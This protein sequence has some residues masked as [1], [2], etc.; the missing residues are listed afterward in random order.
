MRIVMQQ[1]QRQRQLDPLYTFCRTELNKL[2]HRDK[3]THKKTNIHGYHSFSHHSIALGRLLLFFS[4]SRSFAFFFVFLKA[5]PAVDSQ[6]Q[7]LSV[8]L[9]MMMM[10][11][12]MMDQEMNQNSN[13]VVVLLPD[14]RMSS[15]TMVVTIRS[16]NKML[17]S[18]ETIEVLHKQVY[19]ERIKI[20]VVV[21][22]QLNRVDVDVVV[23]VVDD[24][25]DDDEVVV[26]VVQIDKIHV[27]LMMMSVKQVPICH[28]VDDMYLH[29]LIKVLVQVL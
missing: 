5:E 9:M 12:S 28:F 13:Q 29:L 18:K 1:E 24:D 3:H 25:D 7:Y 15:M 14:D 11:M 10:M 8:W 20:V 27:V 4:F 16:Y 23:V 2:E 21:V 22:V 17:Y 19:N 6:Q 26:N